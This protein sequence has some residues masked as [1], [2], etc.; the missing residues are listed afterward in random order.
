MLISFYIILILLK[1]NKCKL[2]NF[3]IDL[4]DFLFLHFLFVENNCTNKAGFWEYVI[5]KWVN[6]F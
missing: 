2:N 3:W 5:L 4:V 6:I 1:N